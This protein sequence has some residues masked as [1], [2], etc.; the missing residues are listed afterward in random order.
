[1]AQNNLG[2]NDYFDGIVELLAKGNLGTG[3]QIGSGIAGLGS[4]AKGY[5]TGRQDPH[6]GAERAVK[7]TQEY[8]S[9]LTT[10]NS[11]GAEAIISYIANSPLGAGLQYI[12]DEIQKS[13]DYWANE[14]GSPVTASIVR[15]GPASLGEVGIP[16]VSGQ[17]VS[18]AFNPNN[19]KVDPVKTPEVKKDLIAYKQHQEKLE[20][21]DPLVSKAFDKPTSN[22]ETI[23]DITFDNE[24]NLTKNLPD[25]DYSGEFKPL[26]DGNVLESFRKNPGVSRIDL[27]FED[28]K[29]QEYMNLLRKI[30][31]R[32]DAI[33]VS[34][35]AQKYSRASRLKSLEK[36]FEE[37]TL[38]KQHV[39]TR[40]AQK[41]Y[42]GL[43]ESNLKTILALKDETK[44]AEKIMIKNFHKMNNA[45]NPQAKVIPKQKYNQAK[46]IFDKNMDRLN[47]LLSTE[48]LY[49]VYNMYQDQLRNAGGYKEFIN[50]DFERLLRR[51]VQP[52]G[53]RRGTSRYFN[54]PNDMPEAVLKNRIKA[55]QNTKDQ[56]AFIEDLNNYI[57]PAMNKTFRSSKEAVKSLNNRVKHLFKRDSNG[58]YKDPLMRKIERDESVDPQALRK[59]ENIVKHNR[60]AKATE[61]LSSIHGV[62]DK[63]LT[64]IIASDSNLLNIIFGT[65]VLTFREGISGAED[66]LS[67]MMMSHAFVDF[68]TIKNITS[69]NHNPDRAIKAAKEILI[70]KGLNT[71]GDTDA[72]LA[73]IFTAKNSHQGKKILDRLQNTPLDNRIAKA[74][75]QSRQYRAALLARTAGNTGALAGAYTTSTNEE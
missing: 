11:P 70:E 32:Y 21:V 26:E 23:K 73:Y 71:P 27:L 48:S 18:R 67:K 17:L 13:A 41:G 60:Y 57:R 5:L 66:I 56:L 62:S 10:L 46:A 59:L 30:S 65:G 16:Y 63:L 3:V 12:S 58:L 55:I 9:D 44:R 25:K 6:L 61:W 74:Y 34:G 15:G 4:L 35:D 64:K 47:D 31:G 20:A 37:E 53:S 72:I 14:K 40:S 69:Y 75:K 68:Q 52:G 39:P 22:I 50:K 19:I 45:S 33:N 43:A 49:N 29:T 28:D 36:G 51:E 24:Y 1:M 38:L 8:W 7:D 2:F 42:R 54:D